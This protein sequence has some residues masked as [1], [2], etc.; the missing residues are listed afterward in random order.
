MTLVKHFI[1]LFT[2][3]CALAKKTAWHTLFAHAQFPQDFW[4]FENFRKICSIALTCSGLH[5]FPM[6][7]NFKNNVG[8]VNNDIIVRFS[9]MASNLLPN[10]KIIV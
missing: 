2:G 5:I 8:M 6:A 1:A 10:I 4:E 3:S 9:L 7:F